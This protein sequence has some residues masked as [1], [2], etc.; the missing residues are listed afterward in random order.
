MPDS[1]F[2]GTPHSYRPNTNMTQWISQILVQVQGEESQPAVSLRRV[3]QRS[4]GDEPNLR[5]LSW[6]QILLDRVH[7]RE[8]VSQD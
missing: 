6:H 1:R 7:G 5:H 3:P 8:H 2:V 4:L